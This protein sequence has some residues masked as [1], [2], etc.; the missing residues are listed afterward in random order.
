[1][2]RFESS[3][4]DHDSKTC[5]L[6]VEDKKSSLRK[7]GISFLC[8]KKGKHISRNC[9]SG[10]KCERCSSAMHNEIICYK[11]NSESRISDEGS[12]KNQ[13]D[14]KQLSKPCSQSTNNEN[15]TSIL[16]YKCSVQTPLKINEIF[17]Q[18]CSARITN[19]SNLNSM[20]CVILYYLNEI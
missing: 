3:S 13:N 10:L 12:S 17:L 5:K 20:Q 16:S 19:N 18:T 1:M 4:S 14:Q 2:H 11:Q 9:F 8:L 15:E 6:N 7:Q